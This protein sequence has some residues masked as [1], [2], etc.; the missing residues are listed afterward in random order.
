MRKEE[1]NK[2]GML[3]GPEIDFCFSILK[4]S[5]VNFQCLPRYFS[6]ILEQ[7]RESF[8]SPN[9]ILF[10]MTAVCTECIKQVSIRCTSAR[11][12]K[13]CLSN[14]NLCIDGQIKVQLSTA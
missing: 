1:Q 10:P 3:E 8:Y 4:L 9:A 7:N 13:S 11:S 2:K 12:P 14:S 5:Y 6:L